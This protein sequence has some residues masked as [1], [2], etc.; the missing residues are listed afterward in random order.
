MALKFWKDSGY[1]KMTEQIQIL[2]RADK[3]YF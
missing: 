3:M 1:P 2:F